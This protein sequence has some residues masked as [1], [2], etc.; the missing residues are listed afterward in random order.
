MDNT[1]SNE[2]RFLHAIQMG[3][4]AWSWG[5]RVVW[6]YGRT[7]TDVEIREAFQTSIS[8]G[9][10]LIDTAEAYGG[11][12]SERLLGQFIRESAGQPALVA[13]KFFPMPWRFGPTSFVRALRGSLERLQLESVDLY[14]VHVPSP[15][16]SVETM[17][18]G[19]RRC[20]EAGL[21]RTVGVSNFSESLTIRSYSALAR[22]NIPLASNQVHYSLLNRVIEKNGLLARCAELG[23][24]IIAYSP[25][26]M[27]LLTG[28]YTLENPPPGNRGLRYSRI[29]SRMGAL[30]KLMTE[31]G[32]DHG[33][34][35][36]SQVA[37]NW[38]IRKGALPI[39]G[40]KNADQ[41]SQNAGALGWE[42]T[43]QEVLKLEA[44]S[45]EVAS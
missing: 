23:I 6:Q 30:I 4:G 14:Q 5:D 19:M 25:L 22:H 27:G 32:Q 41:A 43:P 18:E 42:L 26:E 31:I 8:D 35:F 1:V 10:T 3:L 2:T 12:R 15:L 20:V 34:K 39:P 40:A 9:I 44:A 16:L 11:G 38:V 21:T 37:L 45:D 29:I 24:R 13:T 7:H 17:M 33:G 36:V 28:K